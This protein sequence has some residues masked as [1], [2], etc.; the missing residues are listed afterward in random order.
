MNEL[1]TKE[2]LF[3]QGEDGAM[4][5]SN[6]TVNTILQMETQKK[7]IDK[8]YK[9]YREAIKSGMEEYG[10]KKFES[11]DL[12]VTYVEPTEKVGIDTKKLYEEYPSAAFACEKESPVN[13]SV[14]IKVR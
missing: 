13:A 3:V 4:I 6:E 12:I 5:L 8:T 11:D 1:I 10:L 7:E 9:A 14:R 2:M